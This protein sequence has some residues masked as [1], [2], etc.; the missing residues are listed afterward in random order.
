MNRYNNYH[1]HTHYSNI[2]S[3][4]CIVKPEEYITRAIEL[5]GNKALYFSTEHGY[6]GDIHKLLALCDDVCIEK[7]KQNKIYT[8]KKCKDCAYKNV[9]NQNKVNLIGAVE[10]YYVPNRL[11]KDKG[12]YHLMLIAKNMHGYKDINRIISEA[13]VTGFYYKPRIDDELL[14]SVN[15]SNII[16]TTACIA[17]YI[18]CDEIIRSKK[19]IIKMKDFFKD[20]FYLEVQNHNAPEQKKYNEFLLKCAKEFNIEIIHANDSHYIYP[21]D[22]KYRDLFL[23]G[24]DII[25]PNEKKFILDYPTYDDIV[26]RYKKQ[27]I[28]S[29]EQIK[30]ALDNT[31]IFDNCEPI[32]IDKEIKLPSIFKDSNRELKGILDRELKKIPKEKRLKYKEAVNYEFDIVEKTHMEDYFLL[33]YYIVKRGIEVYNGLLT[34]TGRGSAPSFIINKFLGFTE[35]DR[36]KAPVPLFPTRFMSTVRILQTKSLPDIDL[37]TEDSKP[38]IQATEDLLGKEN[39]A[40]MISFKPLQDGNA[41]RLYCK[42]LDMKVYEYDEVAK[43]LDDYRNNPK[44]KDIIEESKHFIGVI[45][46]I[47]PSPC[48]AKDTLV[49]TKKG[50]KKIQDIKQGDYVLTHNNRFKKVLT[51]MKNKTESILDIKVMGSD[52]IQ[53][54]FNHPFYVISKKGRKYT[55]D[56]KTNKY[57]SVR[58]FTNPYWKNAKELEKGDFISFPINNKSIIP[59]FSIDKYKNK[60]IKENVS[61]L[62]FNNKNLWWVIGRYLGDGWTRFQKN[63]KGQIQGYTVFICCNKKDNEKEEIE[64]KLKGLFNYNIREEPTTYKFE[65]NNKSL[66]MYLQK[67]GKYAYE[68]FIPNEVIDLPINLLSEFLNGYFNTNGYLSNRSSQSCTSISK[69]L[70]LG[71]QQCVHK[72]YK[73]PTTII[74][75][76]PSKSVINGRETID[77][78]DVYILSICINSKYNQGFYQDGYMWQPFKSSIEHEYN[79]YVYNMSVEDDES[80][81]VNNIAVHNCSMLLYNKPI[82][83]EIGLIRTKDGICCNI[84]GYHTDLYKYLKNDY[85]TVKVWKLIRK[86]CEL[87]NIKIPSIKEFNNLLDDKTYNIYEK[88]LTCTINQVDSEYGTNLVKKYKPKSLAEMSAF[89]ASIR[90]GFAS[91]LNNFIERKPYTT[92][93]KELDNLLEDSYH[94]MLYQES[95]MK[96]LIWLGIDESETYGIIKKI[97]KKKFKENELQELK[98]KL[99]KNWLNVVKTEEGFNETWQVVNDASRYS[100]NAS[101]S[102]SYAYDSLYGAYLKSH[103]PLEYYTVALNFYIDDTDRTIKL[104]NELKYFGIKLRNPLFRHSKGEYFFDKENNSIYKGIGS[105]KYL[106]KQVGEDLYT[107]RDI[108]FDSFVD[109]LKTIS[110]N[111]ITI[112]TRQLTILI[113]IGFFEEFGKTQKLLDIL[114]IFNKYNDKKQIN[115]NCIFDYNLLKQYSNKETTKKFM[116]EGNGIIELLKAYENTLPNEDMD[117]RTRIMDIFKYAG[118]CNIKDLRA[119]KTECLVLDLDTKYSPKIKLYCIR[120]GKTFNAKISKSIFKN[121]KI[122]KY[123]LII[124]KEMEKRRKTAKI[125]GKFKKVEGYDYWIL[126]YFKEII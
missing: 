20:N 57:T 77:K 8:K 35:I 103:Y 32:F 60:F 118:D 61:E 51:P 62:N 109:L 45:E 124:V 13:N 27:G 114:E 68:K 80:Y 59:N 19:W 31:L 40:W 43:N 88:G 85:L 1:K 126:T 16:V 28:L 47:S 63:N 72:V 107:L 89:V 113:E 18:D 17:S 66:Y 87:A 116:F 101:H 119:S 98:N 52:I 21:N 49:L 4:D 123:D 44:W 56:K 99:H 36:L 64:N 93:V 25:Y 33:D 91:L 110:D 67:F 50:Y 55:K 112:N 70:I 30:K 29:D 46:S 54:T 96:Y 104:M 79:D 83:E 53:A 71:I 92:N 41:F 75:T 82:N 111:N 74:K 12:N 22:S 94:Y 2:R 122:E 6:Q 5:D 100:F 65:I 86:T 90:P 24:K 34:K 42:S 10:A 15:P 102:L 125:D 105:I 81:T 95:V 106:N 14:F 37:N 39:C 26:D 108:N 9:C 121:N 73:K 23:K 120:T 78:H 58:V 76:K 117:I 38:F 69:K 97:A 11:E 48:F 115:K 84:D 3:L 7:T